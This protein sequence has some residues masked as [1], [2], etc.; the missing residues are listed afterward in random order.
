MSRFF[1]RSTSN[2][3]PTTDAT[4]S[5]NVTTPPSPTPTPAP[6]APRSPATNPLSVE[7]RRLLMP[8]DAPQPSRNA[9]T[10]PLPAAPHAPM[11]SSTPARTDTTS[12]PPSRELPTASHVPPFNVLKQNDDRIVWDL[13]KKKSGESAIRLAAVQRATTTKQ[14][15]Q[16]HPG[17]ASKTRADFEWEFKR[18]YFTL[19]GYPNMQMLSTEDSADGGEKSA[20][21]TNVCRSL[22]DWPF[23]LHD[24]LEARDPHLSNQLQEQLDA[25]HAD[26]LGLTVDE[27]SDIRT[28][29]GYRKEYSHL[30]D[31]TIYEEVYDHLMFY[32]SDTQS[33]YD[34]VYLQIVNPDGSDVNMVD[35][36][37][38]RLDQF[39]LADLRNCPLEQRKSMIEA[40]AKEIEGLCQNG[41]FQFVRELP[42]KKPL[43]SR[44]VL[45]VKYRADGAYDKHKGRLVV[46]GFQAMPGVDFFSTYSPMATMTT[47]RMV[48]SIAVAMDLDCW[49]VDI[50]QAFVQSKIDTPIYLQLPD[51]ITVDARYPNGKY[52]NRVVRL[53]RALYGLKQSPQLWN[54]ELNRILTDVHGFTRSTSDS[55][56]YYCK[57]PNNGKFVLLVAEV[58][59]LVITGSDEEKIQAVKRDFVSRYK[60]TAWERIASFLGINIKYD[61][62]A[63]IMTLDVKAKVDDLF[64]RY[65]ILHDCQQRA[66]PL[67]DLKTKIDDDKK[68]DK[69]DEFIKAKYSSIVGA[70]IYMS[71]TC[72]ADIALAVGKCSRGMHAPTREHVYMLRCLVGY[73]KIHRGVKLTYRRHKTRIQSIYKEISDIDSSLQSICGHDYAEMK[74]PIV[75][76]T[77]ADFASGT[78]VFRRSISGMAFFLYGNLVQWRSKLQPMTAKSTHAAELIALSFAADEGVWLR[79]LLL[80][81]GFVIP[82]VAR[83]VPTEREA[84]GE[85]KDLMD[86][87]PQLTPPIMCDNKGTTFTA[88]NPATDIN[89]KALETRWY[90]IRDYV[91]DGL[92][93]VFH[94]GTNLNVS[95]FFTK[96]LQGDKFS[97]FRNFL[98]GDYIRKDEVALSIF[99]QYPS[100]RTSPNPSCRRVP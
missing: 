80:E 77:D 46:K 34:E 82:H 61:R 65:S 72:R 47:V 43:S 71:T 23:Y 97:D 59:D 4:V 85:Y 62:K 10:L 44:L 51:G 79:R 9:P 50:P 91:K 88:N 87:G 83:V 33:Q 69:V 81:I 14:Y 45:K 20:S 96:P 28:G 63:G 98:M 70:L 12:A 25:L 48:L 30:F 68:M 19:P 64:T 17:P 52:D 54:K 57:N 99:A 49:H 31:C 95:D 37:D 2:A 41:V 93:R 58:D 89:N 24:E 84:E 86:I 38:I 15:A 90:N 40:I 13:T 42:D 100:V 78:E 92:L 53:L 94:I 39:K 5:R 75:G 35:A 18:G 6:P 73:L 76:M 55:C 26:I 32:A 22:D 74:D 29:R 36:K 3:A 66:N 27:Y 11:T 16:L 7:P 67:P 60:I 56:L 8:Y 1:D 21:P